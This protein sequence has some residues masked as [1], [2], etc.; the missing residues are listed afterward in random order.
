MDS[1]KTG[2]LSDYTSHPPYLSIGNVN[3]NFDTRAK[4]WLHSTEMNK[5]IINRIG[6]VGGFI[7]GEFIF[8]GD[9]VDGKY[10]GNQIINPV[11]TPDGGNPISTE[12]KIEFNL[13]RVQ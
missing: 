2:E 4:F 9:M 13:K 7:Q 12:V 5:L 1:I 10:V 6:G 3:G 8:T 11:L